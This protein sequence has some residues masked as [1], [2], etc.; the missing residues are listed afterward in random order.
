MGA[1]SAED[2]KRRTLLARYGITL[3][4]YMLLSLLQDGKCAICGAKDGDGVENN[5]SKSLSVDHD[6]KDGTVRGLLCNNCNRGVGSLMDSPELL[7]K[8]ADYLEGTK[9]R[10]G[11]AKALRELLLKK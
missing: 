5:G 8:A 3:A 7:R 9:D 4:D 10:L 2:N 11:K 1:A 6:H